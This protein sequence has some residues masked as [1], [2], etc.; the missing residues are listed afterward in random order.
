MSLAPPLKE[1]G[2][3]ELTNT[4]WMGAVDGDDGRMDGGVDWMTGTINSTAIL[5][6]SRTHPGAVV[7]AC[8]TEFDFFFAQQKLTIITSASH[9][10]NDDI[11]Q[12]LSPGYTFN[13]MCANATYGAEDERKTRVESEEWV[14][15]FSCLTVLWFVSSK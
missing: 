5:T 6:Y 12:S 13:H 9:P 7:A 14:V 10:L 8:V 11:V 4:E 2:E 15:C 3:E 1:S